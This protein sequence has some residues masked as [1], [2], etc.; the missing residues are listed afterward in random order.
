[1]NLSSL[2]FFSSFFSWFLQSPFVSSLFRLWIH[3]SCGGGVP[4]SRE[5]LWELWSGNPTVGATPSAPWNTVFQQKDTE[6]YIFSRDTDH[7]LEKLGMKI[8]WGKIGHL[9][10]KCYQKWKRWHGPLVLKLGLE[11][12]GD[13]EILG[14]SISFGPPHRPLDRFLDR[15]FRVSPST[16]GKTMNRG[17]NFESCML[18]K[19]WILKT[20]CHLP[21]AIYHQFPTIHIQ[22]H[23]LWK[24][25]LQLKTG[26]CGSQPHFKRRLLAL[27]KVPNFQPPTSAYP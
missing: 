26:A 7:E 10:K 12:T 20:T 11:M 4:Q 13:M 24:L 2:E 18:C 22:I 23:R 1:M 25:T 27:L 8:C 5:E 3:R 6:G 14:F 16:G 19:S 17:W 15:H 9:K 21:F